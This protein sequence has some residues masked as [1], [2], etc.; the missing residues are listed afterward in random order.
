MA[1]FRKPK[2]PWGEIVLFFMI[3]VIAVG[4]FFWIILR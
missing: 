4:T 3:A 1:D 2:F